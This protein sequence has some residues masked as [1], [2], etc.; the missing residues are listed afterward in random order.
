MDHKQ[1]NEKIGQLEADISDANT[2][3]N[4]L[5][6]YLNS[7]KFRCGDELDGYVSCKD[8]LYYV[9]RIKSNL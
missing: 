4:E 6:H 5:L 7:E 8:V 3:C 9:M 1:K 2:I